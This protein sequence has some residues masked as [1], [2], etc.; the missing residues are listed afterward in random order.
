[1]SAPRIAIVDDDD[2]LRTAL[3]GLLRSHGYRVCGHPSAE[4]FLKSGDVGRVDCIVSDIHM[5]GMDGLEFKRQLDAI[6][7]GTPV[8]MITGRTHP[9]L[10]AEVSA[11][12]AY[13]PIA[14]PFEAATLLDRIQSAIAHCD[15]RLQEG[16]RG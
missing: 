7:D 14:K 13:G 9:H 6:S 5:P 16:D 4:S 12:G 3:S 11:V 10:D 8:I 2:S 15:R 1:L